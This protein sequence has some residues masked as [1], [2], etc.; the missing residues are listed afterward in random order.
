MVGVNQLLRAIFSCCQT[1]R[2]TGTVASNLSSGATLGQAKSGNSWYLQKSGST[3]TAL[4][5]VV[6]REDGSTLDSTDS[7]VFVQVLGIV[8]RPFNESAAAPAI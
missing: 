7:S 2:P 3:V 5:V 6:P 8:P 4:Y 1:L